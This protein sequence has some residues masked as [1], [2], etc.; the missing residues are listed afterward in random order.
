MGRYMHSAHTGVQSIQVAPH[1]Q[2]ATMVNL[3]PG[4]LVRGWR[5][6]VRSSSWWGGAGGRGGG[7]RQG[8]GSAWHNVST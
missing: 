4:L 3:T 6:V 8:P 1:Q 2:S 5:M 7:G